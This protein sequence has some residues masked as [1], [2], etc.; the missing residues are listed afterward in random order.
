MTNLIKGRNDAPK[1]P[2]EIAK[3]KIEM[4]IF[5]LRCDRVDDADRLWQ[6]GI[7]ILDQEIKNQKEVA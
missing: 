3:F 7:T 1:S 5:L 2:L 6:D 4:A